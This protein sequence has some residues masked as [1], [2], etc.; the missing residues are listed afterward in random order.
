MTFKDSAKPQYEIQARNFGTHTILG[1][2]H[3]RG[4][5]LSFGPTAAKSE[6]VATEIRYLLKIAD[7][8]VILYKSYSTQFKI[9]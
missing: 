5:K 1:C 4:I 8:T 3:S 6:S 7:I 2:C 9:S